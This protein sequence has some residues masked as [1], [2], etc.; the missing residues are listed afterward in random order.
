MQA[1]LNCVFIAFRL[2]EIGFKAMCG[3]VATIK[4][5]ST[6]TGVQQ[7]HS[8]QNRPLILNTQNYEAKDMLHLMQA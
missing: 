8:R 4:E 3:C 7:Q 6:L 2:A 5:V 1:A